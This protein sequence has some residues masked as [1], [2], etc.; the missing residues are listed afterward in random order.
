MVKTELVFWVHIIVVV[1]SLVVAHVVFVE[2]LIEVALV[3]KGA[4][5]TRTKIPRSSIFTNDV[6]ARRANEAFDSAF[7]LT[8][9]CRRISANAVKVESHIR[10]SAA[11]LGTVTEIAPA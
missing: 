10:R 5:A 1:D 7:F 9:P 4:G 6:L 8:S 2:P 11:A 3:V